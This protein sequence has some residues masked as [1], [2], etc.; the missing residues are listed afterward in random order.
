MLRE[1]SHTEKNKYHMFSFICKIWKNKQ[2]KK[3]THTF[4]EQIG[5]QQM[6]RKIS[7]N[8]ER[9]EEVQVASY[10]S[11]HGDVMYSKSNID[12]NIII[13]T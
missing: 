8:G 1:I 4:R 7:K 6:R 10:K 9:N 2:N 11:S 5:G 12:N 13:I 3:Q